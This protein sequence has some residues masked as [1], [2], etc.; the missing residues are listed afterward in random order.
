MRRAA[1]AIATLAALA[2]PAAAE[3]EGGAVER[4]EWALDA[5]RT[6]TRIWGADGARLHLAPTASRATDQR[7][8][9]DLEL[10][11][12]GGA[13]A[14][15][16]RAVLP[17]TNAALAIYLPADSLLPVTRQPVVLHPSPRRGAEGPRTIGLH[18]GPGAPL[19]ITRSRS[20]QLVRARFRR[21]DIEA[22]GWLPRQAVGTEWVPGA[23]PSSPASDEAIYLGE[24]AS[25]RARPGGRSFATAAGPTTRAHILEKKGR[26]R[27]VAIE[28]GRFG[29]LVGW[30]RSDPP[31][32]R[33]GG[34][35]GGV[36]GGL[37]GVAR[38]GLHLQPGTLLYERPDGEI[39]GV[40]TEPGHFEERREDGDWVAIEVSSD[41]G[42][43]ELWV[44]PD[45]REGPADQRP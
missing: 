34:L 28:A 35:T 41:A 6:G 9:R 17:A 16:V 12:L 29:Y 18:L 42:A 33:L 26:G 5:H 14:G 30:T 11:R 4:L 3:A 43:L 32:V 20:G 36:L 27:L 38:R 37:L 8:A 40:V 39:V 24:K 19:A 7:L 21:G 1:S 10:E 25:L 2:S 23:A 22:S 13:P 44:G 15:W 45:R 31:A